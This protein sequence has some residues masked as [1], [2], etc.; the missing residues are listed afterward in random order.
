MDLRQL[1]ADKV[2]TTPQ[3]VREANEALFRA[4]INLPNAAKHCGMT[5]REMKMTF[6]EYLKWHEVDYNEVSQGILP[7]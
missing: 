1:P 5:E 3:N 2:V 4:R 6:R 7:L